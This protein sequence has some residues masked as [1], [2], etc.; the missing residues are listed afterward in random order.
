MVFRFVLTPRWIVSHV[1]VAALIVGCVF[2]GVW[3]LSRLDDRKAQNRLIEARSELAPVDILTMGA[4]GDLDPDNFVP[5]YDTVDWIPVTATGQFNRPE[6]V[7]VRNRP[8]SGSPGRWV[9]TPLE[10]GGGVAVIVNR[11]WLPQALDVDHPRPEADPPT[12]EVTVTGWLRPSEQASGLQVSDPVDG[13]LLSVARPNI[14][15]LDQQ[16]ESTLLSVFIQLESL[17]E[18]GSPLES[19]LPLPVPL[20]PLD[21]GPHLSYAV[22]WF[23]FA[24]IGFFGYPLVLSRLGR[25]RAN[26][27]AVSR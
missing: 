13:V 9:L 21:Q 27:P 20:P 3:Q 15:R 18:N 17:S 14:E 2:A 24:T 25:S 6:E 5:P 19:G 26:R 7:L 23:I 4:G 22:Q 1:L 12:G 10:L 16:T 11:G 8:R